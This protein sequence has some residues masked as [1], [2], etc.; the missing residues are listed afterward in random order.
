MPPLAATPVGEFPPPEQQGP[1]LDPKPET[2]FVTRG[3]CTVSLSVVTVSTCFL[4]YFD[5]CFLDFVLFL[6]FH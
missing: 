3:N 2:M 5:I 4:R 6:L 1:Q